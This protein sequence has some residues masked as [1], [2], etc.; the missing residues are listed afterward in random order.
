MDT[1]VVIWMMGERHQLSPTANHAI[2]EALRADT[3]AVSSSTLWELAMLQ[4]LNR[5]ILPHSLGEYLRR[6]EQVFA[7]LPLNGAIA[8]RSVQ[9]TKKYPK[10]P[11]DRVIGATAL[12]H[13]LKLVTKDKGIRRS[14]EVPCVW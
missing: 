6:V 4:S 8:E 2:R 3:I 9:F 13:G 7:V 12:V 5:V 14:G 10:D 11:T 1:N